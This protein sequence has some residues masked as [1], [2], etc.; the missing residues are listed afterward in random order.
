MTEQIQSGHS[1][2]SVF[3]LVCYDL[4]ISAQQF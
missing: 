1:R 4:F 3:K 2:V